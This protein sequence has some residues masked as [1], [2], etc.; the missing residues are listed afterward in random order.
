MKNTVVLEV[1]RWFHRR[2]GEREALRDKIQEFLDQGRRKFVV[3]IEDEGRFVSMDV[4]V[5]LGVI[6]LVRTSGGVVAIATPNEKFHTLPHPSA[7]DGLLRFHSVEEAK[8]HVE[9]ADLPQSDSQSA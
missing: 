4:G 2:R 9:A 5:L 1:P 3:F 6:S 8:K 7:S